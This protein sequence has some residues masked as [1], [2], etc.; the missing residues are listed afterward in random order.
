MVTH[1]VI[2]TWIP[3]ATEKQVA[4]VREA[5]DRLAAEVSDMGTIRHGRDLRLRDGAGDYALV[6]TFPDRAGWEAYQ[7]DPRHKAFVHDVV[8]PL[9][10]SRVTAQF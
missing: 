4:G 9:L 5:L 1:L 8:S 2:F 7:D 3:G 10:A 6:A